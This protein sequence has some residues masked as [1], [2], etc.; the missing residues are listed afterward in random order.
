MADVN[1]V[2]TR[3]SSNRRLP[4]DGEPI[5]MT[6]ATTLDRPPEGQ[7]VR[8][9]WPSMGGIPLGRDEDLSMQALPC[10]YP[11]EKPESVHQPSGAIVAA[12]KISTPV[13]LAGGQPLVGLSAVGVIGE[14]GLVRLV[15]E[16]G[17]FLV[18]LP[19]R[20]HGKVEDSD[21]ISAAESEAD[22]ITYLKE[23]GL[24]PVADR[25]EEFFGSAS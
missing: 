1:S 9:G 8:L 24:S 12:G 7:E 25:I 20:G 16:S 19:I 15:S 22:L 3:A 4:Y 21:Y 23:R 11:M 14:S 2:I 17:R 10:Y 6:G 5:F 13:L 18:G